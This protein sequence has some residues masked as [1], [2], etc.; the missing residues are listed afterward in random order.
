M[1]ASCPD[2]GE[3]LRGIS[4]FCFNCGIPL[5]DTGGASDSGE[6]SSRIDASGLNSHTLPFG[7]DRRSPPSSRRNRLPRLDA[8]TTLYR[9]FRWYLSAPAI[10]AVF[11]VVTAFGVVAE[12]THPGLY[13]VF[14]P[15]SV[16]AVGFAHS[17][18]PWFVGQ[19]LVRVVR[20][21][22]STKRLLVRKGPQLL[23]IGIVQSIVVSLG[24]LL[25]VLPGVY[26]GARLSLAYPACI[27]DDR[28]PLDSLCDSWAISKW[29]V[30]KLVG[31]GLFPLLLVVLYLFFLGGNIV[32]ARPSYLI[33]VIPIAASISGAQTLAYARVYL[34]NRHQS[35]VVRQPVPPRER[36]KWW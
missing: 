19:E 9:G 6:D 23:F 30:P 35:E 8:I 14:L 15:A 29:N 24:F 11:L 7:R 10:V 21:P 3:P 18:A 2:C 13:L 28:S 4:T 17:K 16:L 22:A 34:E 5:D 1:Q 26:L 32:P 25:F 36:P 31:I 27:I 12:T 33:F 20:P